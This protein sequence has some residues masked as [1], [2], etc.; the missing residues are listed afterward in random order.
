M[1][2]TKDGDFL[3]LYFQDQHMLDAFDSYPEYIALDATFKL[4]NL[5]LPLYITVMKKF[6]KF[7]KVGTKKKKKKQDGIMMV[8]M[9]L[10]FLLL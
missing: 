7:K 9:T 3:G 10:L 4:I 5:G 1:Y 6:K 2:K 8:P